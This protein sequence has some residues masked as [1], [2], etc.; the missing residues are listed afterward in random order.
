MMRASIDQA[1]AEG[2]KTPVLVLAD[3]STLD[4]A[5][6][7]LFGFADEVRRTRKR[8]H[9]PPTHL[10]EE[11]VEMPSFAKC[12]GWL[13]FNRREVLPRMPRRL[14][15]H[16][17]RIGKHYRSLS[18]SPEERDTFIAIVYEYVEEGKNSFEAVEKVARF[19]WLAGFSFA[20][21]TLAKNWKSGVL[22]DH[23]DIVAPG[24]FGWQKAFYG[25]LN[26]KGILAE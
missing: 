21:Q 10:V 9:F 12:H 14:L 5:R 20:P 1:T 2:G 19:L 15:P 24:F 22:V 4:D 13:P 16:G 26:A 8:E 6:A 3:P 25:R 17:V 18:L 11:V 7:N 23:S